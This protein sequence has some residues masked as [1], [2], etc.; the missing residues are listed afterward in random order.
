[1]TRAEIEPRS[2]WPLANTL[3]L[4]QWAEVPKFPFKLSS[5][6]HESMDLAKDLQ[7]EIIWRLQVQS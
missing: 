5:K 7:G 2:P 4:I 6:T 1:M 3:P